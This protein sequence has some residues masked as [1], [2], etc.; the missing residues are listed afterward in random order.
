MEILEKPHWS[1]LYSEKPERMTMRTPSE[2]LA[3]IL[4]YFGPLAPND[5][6]QKVK[7]LQESN[8]L[9][10]FAAAHLDDDKPFVTHSH[11]DREFD[12]PKSL[13]NKLIEIGYL[14]MHNGLYA[15]PDTKQG[16]GFLSGPGY[17]N[18]LFHEGFLKN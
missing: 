10:L 5:L 14:V 2:F 1:E 6:I 16:R 8:N 12:T 13:A 11:F 3:G 15:V 18:E 17:T 9:R 7:E 4:A